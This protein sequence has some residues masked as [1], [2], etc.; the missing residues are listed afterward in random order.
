MTINPAP[1]GSVPWLNAR[2]GLVTASEAEALLTP[3]F[4]VK[5]ITDKG[6]QTY[7]AQKIAEKWGGPLIGFDSFETDQGTILEAE[8][9]RWVRLQTGKAITEVGL[10]ISDDG[11]AGCSPDGLMGDTGLELKC[12]QPPNHVK[13]LLADAIPSEYIVQ[14]HWSMFVTG[15]E[16]WI[17]CSYRRNFPQLLLTVKRDERLIEQCRRAMTQFTS[18]FDIVWKQM[19]EKNGGEPEDWRPRQVEPAKEPSTI[20]ACVKGQPG[21]PDFGD[22][23]EETK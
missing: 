5:D 4:K 1:Q 7:L 23:W 6:P 15:F 2:C 8:A 14:V 9:R 17:F 16:T 18:A 11:R 22:P 3:L 12:P 21:E 20:D 19:V 13:W 10:C